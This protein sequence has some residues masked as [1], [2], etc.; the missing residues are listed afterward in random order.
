MLEKILKKIEQEEKQLDAML[1][2]NKN[3]DGFVTRAFSDKLHKQQGIVD[4][5][6]AAAQIIEE[7]L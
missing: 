1:L 7:E 2:R 4:G 5:L 6:I 3:A